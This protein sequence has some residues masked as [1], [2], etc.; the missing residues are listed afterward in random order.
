[1]IEQGLQQAGW[2]ANPLEPTRSVRYWNGTQWTSDTRPVSR[3]DPDPARADSPAPPVASG[4]GVN[5]SKVVQ[6]PSGTGLLENSN[7][8]VIRRAKAAAWVGDLFAAFAAFTLVVGL[9]IGARFGVGVLTAFRDSA[10]EVVVRLGL[11]TTFAT[12]TGTLLT[13]SILRLASVLAH[14]VGDRYRGVVR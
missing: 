2:Y 1:M 3:A 13:Y 6:T 8:V 14:Y 7:A 9:L 11:L 4:Q 12:V 5:R 10:D